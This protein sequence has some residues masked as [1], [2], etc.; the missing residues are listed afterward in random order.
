MN[1]GKILLIGRLVVSLA[2]MVFSGYAL[3]E[4]VRGWGWFL[5]AAI[6]ICPSTLSEWRD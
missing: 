4:G 1:D 5:F 6:L 3:F 2:A